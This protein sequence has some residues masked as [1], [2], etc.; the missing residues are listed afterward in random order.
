M[1]E[2][3]NRMMDSGKCTGPERAV[4]DGKGQ[5]EPTG[6]TLC[7]NGRDVSCRVFTVQGVNG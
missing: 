1:Q 6:G 4:R 5:G 2:K 3:G 7:G